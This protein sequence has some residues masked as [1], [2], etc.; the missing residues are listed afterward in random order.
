MKK[1]LYTI[2]LALPII[3]L[4]SCSSAEEAISPNPELYQLSNTECLPYT[5]R[6][7]GAPGSD[8][9]EQLGQST[10]QMNFGDD[11]STCDCKF[12]SLDYPCDFGKVNIKI[13]YADGTLT[14]V[15]YPSSDMA[16]CRCPVD[17]AFSIKNLP[18]G[19]FRL[20]IYRGDTSGKYNPGKPKYEGSIKPVADRVSIKIPY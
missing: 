12:N 11:P 8:G 1:I 10:F 2:V 9:D 18:Q 5:V 7:N 4:A 3:I 6:S 20:K 14:I 17:A 16:D 19:E 13:S 15:E